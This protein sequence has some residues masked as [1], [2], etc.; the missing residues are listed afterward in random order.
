MCEFLL[1]NHV[2]DEWQTHV[3]QGFMQLPEFDDVQPSEIIVA[4][5]DASVEDCAS[6][7]YFAFSC[8]RKPMN[9]KC[10]KKHSTAELC[11]TTPTSPWFAHHATQRTCVILAD[12][13]NETTIV[14][15]TADAAGWM[16]FGKDYGDAHVSP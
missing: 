15:E 13:A 8:L 16:W 5:D 12:G 7:S 9:Y 6:E 3:G 11:S 1:P 14:I 4:K 10:L 2:G